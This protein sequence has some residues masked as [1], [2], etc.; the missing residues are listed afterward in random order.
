MRIPRCASDVTQ[1]CPMPD[2]SPVWGHDSRRSASFVLWYTYPTSAFPSGARC[3]R[4]VR[5]TRRIQV[6]PHC[7]EFSLSLFWEGFLVATPVSRKRLHRR[8]GY[9]GRGLATRPAGLRGTSPVRWAPRFATRGLAPL[10]RFALRNEVA[11][12]AGF[13]FPESSQLVPSRCEAGL[14]GA[15]ALR[16]R[17]RAVGGLPGPPLHRT[18]LVPGIGPRFAMRGSR[19]R[20]RSGFSLLFCGEGRGVGGQEV[21]PGFLGEA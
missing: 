14:E 20:R 7:E 5:Q 17:L 12:T 19:A 13:G 10:R 8:A 1:I 18:V 2:P 11:C 16:R 3:V 4:G 15:V 6:R 21:C 9:A